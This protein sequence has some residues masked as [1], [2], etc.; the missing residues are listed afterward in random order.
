MDWFKDQ[1][2]EKKRFLEQQI[3]G[4][5][6]LVSAEAAL[7]WRDPQAL[8]HLLQEALKS[9]PVARMIYAVNSDCQQIS[10]NISEDG[11]DEQPRGQV[12][13]HRPYMTARLPYRGMVL[14]SPYLS[15]VDREPCITAVQAV[16]MDSNLE[17]FLLVDFP[18]RSLGLED[19]AQVAG[20][21]K[22]YKGDPSI[23]GQLFQQQRIESVMDSVI[24]DCH[25]SAFTL[26][27]KYG[28][29]HCKF[30][31]SSSRVTLWFY[32]D[33]YRYKIH[34]AQELID[35][36]MWLAYPVSQYPSQ[37][38]VPEEDILKVFEQFKTLR[39][40]DENIYLRS[41]SLNIINGMVGLTF[42]CDGSHYIPVQEFL[43]QRSPFWLAE[44]G[45]IAEA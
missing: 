5:M 32:D 7:V 21:W 43:D 25:E 14:S 39:A 16:L 27:Q 18:L 8:D 41:G 38:V 2:S 29:F 22:Q 6:E 9:M 19:S 26:M 13:G 40:A 23:R 33:P 34:S 1:I 31:Y 45:R 35:P 44:Q 10:A 28:V 36:D 4:A 37:A 11:I 12:L 3:A 24:D 15:R 20:I 17:G 30:H 42:S